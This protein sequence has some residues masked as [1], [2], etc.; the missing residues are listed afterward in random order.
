MVITNTLF[1][2]HQRRLYTWT[3]PNGEYKNHIDY[4][5]ISSKWKSSIENIKTKP[6]ADCGSDHQLLVA[7]LRIHLKHYKKPQHKTIQYI[8][9]KKEWER[10]G[11]IIQ[12]K[13]KHEDNNYNWPD[14][15]QV[16]RTTKN[17][18]IKE[19]P[20][21]QKKNCWFSKETIDI[22][23]QR[24]EL[25]VKGLHCTP[26]YKQLSALRRAKEL[27]LLQT[28]TIHVNCSRKLRSSLGTSS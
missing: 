18:T 9:S 3:S 27:K 1:K 16:F 2:H 17:E 12:Q 4:C 8:Y 19:R 5:L 20:R 7:K 28:R 10:F 25:K 11:T 22:I 15:K 26:Q 6:G 24:R 14:L 23:E 13:L 21:N